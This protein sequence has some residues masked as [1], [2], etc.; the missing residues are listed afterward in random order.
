MYV[1]T[2]N[3]QNDQAKTDRYMK[4]PNGIV[5]PI[6]CHRHLFQTTSRG[7]VVPEKDM[8]SILVISSLTCN[9][10]KDS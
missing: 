7:G 2:D 1:V 6:P 8:N 4:V 5:D 3:N 10:C 9:M